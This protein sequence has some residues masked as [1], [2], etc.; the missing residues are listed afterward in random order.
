MA[1]RNRV[2]GGFTVKTPEEIKKGLLYHGNTLCDDDCPYR[3]LNGF[4]CKG[5]LCDDALA[6]I[7]KL[8]TDNAQQARC[9]ENLT[10]KLNATNDALA[11][12]AE[13]SEQYRWERDVAIG[14]LEQLG[15]GFGEKVD[16]KFEQVKR[17]RD[18]L[19]KYLTDSHWAACDICKHEPEEGN[20]HACKRSHYQYNKRLF[21]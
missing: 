3:L 15:I 12:K 11:A 18:F 5:M 21:A 1:D 13:L 19:L 20:I 8:E 9:I 7:Q 4:G 17:E 14:Q 10:D 2:E 6:Y 16:G